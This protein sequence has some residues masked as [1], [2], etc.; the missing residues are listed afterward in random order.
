MTMVVR[1]LYNTNFDGKFIETYKINIFFVSEWLLTTT[2]YMKLNKNAFV[3]LWVIIDVDY[4]SI[5]S[6]VFIVVF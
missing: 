5:T 3:K 6:T 1:Q 4:C 2:L